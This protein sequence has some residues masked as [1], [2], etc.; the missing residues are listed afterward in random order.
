ML[1]VSV[2]VWLSVCTPVAVRVD[3]QCKAWS[4]RRFSSVACVSFGLVCIL[5][6]FLRFETKCENRGGL[7]GD[8][9][10][11]SPPLC[12]WGGDAVCPV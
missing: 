12:A 11:W 7:G 10:V 8:R 3:S 6:E 5:S 9:G 1:L 4:C 2:L